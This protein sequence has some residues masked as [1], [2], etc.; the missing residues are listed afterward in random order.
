MTKRWWV[1][2][3]GRKLYEHTRVTDQYVCLRLDDDG[4]Y[5]MHPFESETAPTLVYDPDNGLVAQDDT[6]A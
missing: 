5:R 3:C 6:A 4:E 1:C 2:V